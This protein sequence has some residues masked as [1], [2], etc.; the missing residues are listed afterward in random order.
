M[1][2]LSKQLLDIYDTNHKDINLLIMRYNSTLDRKPKD[3]KGFFEWLRKEVVYPDGD[4]WR[5]KYKV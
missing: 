2:E 3:T 1:I 4:I 5:G